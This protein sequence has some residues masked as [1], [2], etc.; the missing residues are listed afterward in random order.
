[1]GLAELTDA[2]CLVVSE[3]RGTVSAARHGK[4]DELP[5]SEGLSRILESFYRELKSDQESAKWTEFFRRNY[6]QKAL[7]FG[8]A[9]ALWF[10]L[11][12]ESRTVY[13][14]YDIPLRS[15]ELFSGLMVTHIEPENVA[16]TL[17][18]Q[19]KSFYFFNENDIK[20]NL[21]LW[22]LGAGKSTVRLSG[23]DFTI[24]EGLEYEYAAP[25]DVTVTIESQTQK[26]GDKK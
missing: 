1:L 25:R 8:L 23:S 18:G 9:L 4:I 16:V 11:V 22:Q 2:L 26:T 13:R 17:S 24:P 20:L 10:V 7:A 6:R 3:E 19:R 12:H 5:E 21:R 14:T 15:A